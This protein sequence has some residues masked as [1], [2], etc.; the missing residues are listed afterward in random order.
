MEDYR[1]IVNSMA[2]NSRAVRQSLDEIAGE[3]KNMVLQLRAFAKE[4]DSKYKSQITAPAYGIYSSDFAVPKSENEL[5]ERVKNFGDWLKNYTGMIGFML[6]TVTPA[7]SSEEE[8]L[9]AK[10]ATSEVGFGRERQFYNMELGG[11]AG[12]TEYIRRIVLKNYSLWG[13]QYVNEI[14]NEYIK[15][16]KSFV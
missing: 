7:G 1:R 12:F 5:K 3:Y 11:M 9:K 14:D 13:N 15:D 6:G 4:M 10:V 2:S 8:Q 16:R